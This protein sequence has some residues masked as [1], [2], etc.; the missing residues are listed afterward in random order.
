[1]NGGRIASRRRRYAGSSL[2]ARTMSVSIHVGWIVPTATPWWATSIRRLL[3]IAS[4]PALD[5]A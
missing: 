1:M 2:A 4:T 5:A 3:H